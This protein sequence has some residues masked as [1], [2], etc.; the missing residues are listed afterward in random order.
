LFDF[1]LLIFF[2]PPT[3]LH[4]HA[5]LLKIKQKGD[6]ETFH[7]LPR[8]L[9]QLFFTSN[10]FIEINL[11][12]FS[13]NIS[14]TIPRINSQISRSLKTKVESEKICIQLALVSKNYATDDIIICFYLF[15]LPVFIWL[16]SAV[17]DSCF[18]AKTQTDKRLATTTAADISTFLLRFREH[19]NPCFVFG[20][21]IIKSTYSFQITFLGKTCTHYRVHKHIVVAIMATSFSSY[22]IFKKFSIEVPKQH[23]KMH[24]QIV[25]RGYCNACKISM[26]RLFT[27]F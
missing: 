11:V 19:L 2:Q 20:K 26:F 8:R 1:L 4:H 5:S 24:L 13:L 6:S 3:L 22:W 23:S 17:V 18:A 27:N 10:C 9:K 16:H 15:L 7:S 21:S 25:N 14:T 12:L